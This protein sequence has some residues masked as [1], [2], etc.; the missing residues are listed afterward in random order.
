MQTLLLPDPAVRAILA[1]IVLVV[2]F[3]A[4]RVYQTIVKRFRGRV[5]TGLVA[6]FQQFGSWVLWILG[7]II[8]LSMLSVPIEVPELLIGLGGLALILAYRDVLTVFVSS[9][10]LTTYQP[11]KVGEWVEIENHYGRVIETDLIETKLLTPNNEIVIIPNS[12]LMRQSIVNK[13]RAGTL[14]VKIPIYAKRGLDL[15][16]LEGHLLEIARGMKVDLASDTVP[17]VRVAEL[18]PEYTRL[19]LLIEIANPAKRDLIVSEIQKRV[20]ELLQELERQLF[21]RADK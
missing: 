4:V 21:I 7:V 1:G 3:I 16:E 9:Q 10:F 11:I 2:T 6:S 19:E 12:I 15:A 17:E 8:A 20:Y 14:R 5:P 18:M 13:T